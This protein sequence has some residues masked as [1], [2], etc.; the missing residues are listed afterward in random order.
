MRLFASERRR[1]YVLATLWVV[2]VVLGVGGYLQQSHDAGLGRSGLDNL[3]LTLQLATLD[4]NG[5]GTAINWRLQI[6][7]FVAP[8]MAAS[9]LLQAASVVFRDQ[10]QRW[11]VRRFAGHTVVFGLGPVGSRLALAL[12]ADGRRVVGVD[13]AGAPGVDGLRGNGLPVV[14]GDSTDPTVLRAARA[15]HATSVIAAHGD[16]AQNVTLATALSG[17]DFPAGRAPL[18]CSVHLEDLS[19]TQLLTTRAIGGASAVRTEFFNV[20]AAAARSLVEQVP[21]VAAGDGQPHVVV[22]GFGR[23][24]SSVLVALAQRH[25]SGDPLRVTIV[26]PGSSGKWQA[27]VMRHP[28]LVDRTDTH[29]LDLDLRSPTQAVAER[30]LAELVDPRPTLV[31]I[32]TDEESDALTTGLFVYHTLADTSVPIVVRTRSDSGLAGIVGSAD[33]TSGFP[34]LTVFPFLDRACTID[35]VEGGIREQI[36]RSVHADHLA[37]STTPGVGLHR[38]WEQLDDAERESSRASA[39]GIVSGLTGLGYRLV[40]LARWDASPA[41]LGEEE[42]DALAAAEHERWRAERLAA[43]WAYGDV[44]DDASKRN[45]LLVP[46]SDLPTDARE[47]NREA[48]DLIPAQ[49]A[50]AGVTIVDARFAR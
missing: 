43:G 8:V 22:A 26:D 17:L 24:G 50:R 11:R 27:L 25:E 44:R 5:G 12:A 42:R 49:L 29:C 47:R 15:A 31:V 14:T 3:Y 9:T 40:P 19:L 37:H 7:R 28:G 30:F 38:P 16:D 23:F 39:D 36:A 41:P 46:W 35:M 32:A 33:E 48:I 1:W 4:Y 2:V 20:H 10:F 18:R 21:G 13:V 45:P 34:G 6:A